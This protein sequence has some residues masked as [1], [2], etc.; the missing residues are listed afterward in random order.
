MLAAQ[1]KH[2]PLVDLLLIRGADPNLGRNRLA[3]PT[4]G[5]TALHRTSYDGSFDIA[6][7]LLEGGTNVDQVDKIGMSP[8]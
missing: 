8:L 3:G 4:E 2:L 6:E 1:E 5:W 7:R